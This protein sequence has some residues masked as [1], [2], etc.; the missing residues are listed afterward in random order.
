MGPRLTPAA[1]GLLTEQRGVIASWQAGTVGMSPRQ[2][3]HACTTSWQR[4][5]SRTYLAGEADPTPE[6]LRVAGVLH[7]GP[8]AWL[9]GCSALVESGW[10]GTD[11]GCVDVVVARDH[12]SR[13]VHT[14]SWLRVRQT[15]EVPRTH[16]R[17]ARTSPARAA[18]DAAAWARSPR[19]RMFILVST[20][21]QRLVT[22]HQLRRELT[23]R[24]RIPES[25][26][27]RRVLEE[28]EGGATST[29]EVDFRRECR[30]RGLPTPRMQ[31]VRIAGGRRRR[32]DA[33]FRLPDGRMV[34]VEIDGV[35]HM[36]VAQWQADLGRQNDVALG[37]GA[38]ILHVTSWQVRNDPDPF[39]AVLESALT[40][41][42]WTE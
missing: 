27:M 41:L 8:D 5:T 7:A 14:P 10:A 16:G 13:L 2:F 40:P 31:V 12:R 18:I 29:A 19:E 25:R 11:G 37:T 30:R 21:Q 6:Q 38:L 26:D 39:F 24:G 22:V 36:E 34:I 15:I 33:E 32:I 17:P 1:R 4:V 23:R 28:I 35:A 42:P 9:A 20:V 3:A